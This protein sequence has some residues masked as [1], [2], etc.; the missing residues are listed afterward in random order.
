[1]TKDGMNKEEKAIFMG[2]LAV[3]DTDICAPFVCPKDGCDNCPLAPVIEAHDRF[4][5]VAC[6]V[7]DRQEEAER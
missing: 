2:M 6:R 7:S 4:L 3:L 1:M 5:D